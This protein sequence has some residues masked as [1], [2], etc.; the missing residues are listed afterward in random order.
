[1]V[2]H[3]A[4]F[5]LPYSDYAMRNLLSEGIHPK[6]IHK[7]G[8]PIGE[9][10]EHFKD[11]IH[12]ST[13]LSRLGLEPKRYFLA[14]LHRQENVDEPERLALALK[15]LEAIRKAFSLPVIVSTHPRTRKRLEASGSQSLEGISFMDPFGYLDY[16]KL[17][18]ESACVISDSGTVSE[19]ASIMRF[20]GVSL[21]GSFERPESLQDGCMLFVAPGS[22]GLI[23]AISLVMGRAP[24]TRI[25]E[26]YEQKNFSQSVL[27]FLFTG[28]FSLLSNREI[29]P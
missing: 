26:G 4:T 1:M 16:N 7:T 12:A 19:E 27:S 20:A 25:P 13:I 21:R 18:L 5:N 14:S 3:V 23:G 6:F 10:Y 24:L 15:S 17:Q 8:S 2:D 29:Q 9:I 22:E 28:Q 11:R